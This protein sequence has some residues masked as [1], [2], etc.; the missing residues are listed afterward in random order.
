M[1]VRPA[2]LTLISINARGLNIPEK[3]S[4]ALRDFQKARASVVFI[5]ESHFRE[6]AAPRLTNSWFPLGFFGNNAGTKS[7]GVVILFHKTVPFVHQATLADKEGR[8]VMVRGEISGRRYTFVNF[9]APN[10]GQHRF[11]AKLLPII[12]D[13]SDGCLVLGGDLNV[14]LDPRLD[15]SSG[16]SAIPPHVTRSISKLLHTHRLVDCW[17]ATHT[18]DKDY[19]YFSHPAQIYS[20]LDYFFLPHY[21]L[22]DLQLVQIGSMTWSD[23]AP[24]TLRLL[25]PL[26]RPTVPAWRLN[27]FLL[28]DPL[29]SN[30]CEQ[31]L[32]LYFQDNETPNVSPLSIWEAHKCVIRGFYIRKASEHKKHREAATVDLLTRIHQLETLHKES[33]DPA[34]LTDL[35][36]LRRELATLLN[37]TYH[38]HCLRSKTFFFAHGDKSGRL[39][40]RMLRTRQS[41][42]YIAKIR[43]VHGK[44][45]HLPNRILPA[46]RSYFA[47]LYDLPTPMTDAGRKLRSQKIHAFLAQH[48]TRHLTPEAAQLLDSPLTVEELSDAVKSSKTGKCPGP[49]G[50]PLQYY[51][52]FAKILYPRFLVAFNAILEGYAIPPQTQAANI[53]LIPRRVKMWRDA[54]AIAP[55][56]Y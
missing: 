56:L 51:K 44:T 10:K 29:T 46:I 34:Q 20:R 14:P 4:R 39:L 22:P 16:R 23:H 11:M 41:A 54:K 12:T 15:T 27:D 43:D 30:D 28:T 9:Y 19:T 53:T 2:A 31:T 7:K 52:R 6:G 5:Q 36:A 26:H 47:T 1:A 21:Y 55:S 42:T 50:L 13:F 48:V 49:D 37:S 25:S 40:A 33:L 18:E 24:V 8:Y 17:R 3:R 45:Q 38:C 32:A 35:T